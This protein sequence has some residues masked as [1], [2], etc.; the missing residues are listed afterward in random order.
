MKILIVEDEQR[1]AKYLQKGLKMQGYQVDWRD[2]GLDGY[3]LASDDDYDLLILDW[4]LPGMSGVEI[5]KNL[6]KDKI[7]TP[8]LILTAKSAIDD[9]VGGLDAGAD[10][11]LAKPFEFAE[12][13]ARVRALLRRKEKPIS[14]NYRIADLIIDPNTY[15]VQRNGQEIQL[16]RQ[17]FALLEYLA[18]N[19][20]R[21]FSKEELLEKVWSYDSDA[22]PNTVQVY[23]GYLRNKID[24]NFADLKP[25]IHTVRGFGY[26]LES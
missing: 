11:Y 6:R 16:S 25:L 12:L 18:R 23:I 14:A 3:D 9:K 1:I 17:E 15:Q 13:L 19:P 26:K 4:M 20:G 24:R 5:C 8:I 22:L 10:D 21:I 2:N 7:N